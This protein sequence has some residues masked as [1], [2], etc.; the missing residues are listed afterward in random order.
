[1]TQKFSMERAKLVKIA[2]C[3][4]IV[5]IFWVMPAPAPMTTAGI[6]VIGVFIATVILL[7]AVDTVWL[8][9]Q[10]YYCP[11]LVQPH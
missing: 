3:F 10:S 6:R 5:A 2:I 7:S 4:L 8:C 9:W 1:M 11:E